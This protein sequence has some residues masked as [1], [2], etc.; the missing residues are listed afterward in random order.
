MK[1]IMVA[2][3]VCFLLVVST[4]IYAQKVGHI[5]SIELLN[6]LDE[7][8]SAQKS[9]ETYASQLKK[10]LDTKEKSLLEDYNKVMEQSQK[11][12]LTRVEEESK[13]KEFQDRQA[14]LES[15]NM[16]AQQDLVKRENELIEPIRT[17]VMNTIESVAKENGYTYVL[18]ISGGGVLFAEDAN[19]ITSQVK[20]KL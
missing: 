8:K 18:D 3:G 2:I 13:A 7:F 16:K 20:S 19:D 14:A 17:R 5:N 9:L 11:G 15:A 12:N 1:K 10:D 6:G 4:N